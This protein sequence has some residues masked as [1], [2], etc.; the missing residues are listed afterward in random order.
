MDGASFYRIA[1]DWGKITAGIP[2]EPMTVDQNLIPDPD[3]LTKEQAESIFAPSTN[4]GVTDYI[5]G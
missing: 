4:A 2:V 1:G 5:G 3:T